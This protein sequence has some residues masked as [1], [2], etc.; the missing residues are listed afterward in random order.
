[1]AIAVDDSCPRR[2]SIR[3]EPM[4]DLVVPLYRLPPRDE[5][6]DALNDKGITIRRAN[7]FEMSIVC[8]F[9]R[10]DFSQSWADETAAVFGRQPVGCYIAVEQ[11][12]V[13][14]FATID[15]TRRGY[16]GPTGV[17]AAQRGRGVGRA[18]L[19]AA[20]W[21]LRDLGYGY[22][23]IGAAGP[24]DFYEKTVHAMVIPDSTPGVY[25]DLLDRD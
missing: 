23:I 19:I 16:F 15:S 3:S 5:G 7:T 9:I 24:V 14:G 12:K 4:P 8:D 6:E 18:L 20:L 10:R 22:G 11:R 13:I 1:L 25:T 2:N 17:D 21:G